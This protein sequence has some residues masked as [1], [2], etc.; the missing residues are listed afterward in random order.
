MGITQAVPWSIA[1]LVYAKACDVY[2]AASDRN[3]EALRKLR[4]AEQALATASD[5]LEDADRRLRDAQAGASRGPGGVFI[6]TRREQLDAEA[7]A[8]AQ[9]TRWDNLRGYLSDCEGGTRDL[10]EKHPEGVINA[11]LSG[12]LEMLAAIASFMD[13]QQDGTVTRG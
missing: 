9:R 10:R 13:G 12:Q 8:A 7:S 11:V 6:G 1:D 3:R 4:E 2:N 5:E